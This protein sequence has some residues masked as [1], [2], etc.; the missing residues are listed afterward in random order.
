MP[1]YRP[2]IALL[3]F[4]VA[5]PWFAACQSD[6]AGDPPVDDPADA[7][8][9]S[10]CT[11]PSGAGTEHSGTLGADE[12]W[13]AAGSPHVIRTNLHV[14]TGVTLTL[15]PCAVVRIEG[16]L[17]ILV[18]GAMA[19]EGAAGQPIRIERADSATAW[20]S[21]ETRTGSSLRLAYATVAG[22]GEPNGGR[23]TQFGML[24]IRGDVQ[25]PAEPSFFVDHVVLEDSASIG[26]WLSG[27]AGFAPGS[28]ELTI[29]K[30]AGFPMAVWS[31]AIWT[32]P[33]SGSFTGNAIDEIW[34]PADR[35]A[36]MEDTTL[37]DLG[38]P[39]RVGGLTGGK[40]LGVSGRDGDVALLTIEPGVTLRFEP[41]VVLEIPA[42]STQPDGKPEG[43]LHA[44]GTAGQPIVF[45]SALETPAAG[46]WVGIVF[47]GAP[48]PRNRMEYTTIAYAGAHSG[49]SSFD[50][51]SPANEGFRNAG[52]ILFA[53]G[54]PGGFIRNSTIDSSA[55]DGIVRGWTGEPIDMLA[56]NTFT[57]VA[58]CNQTFPKPK[59]GQ[60][61]DPAPC[62]K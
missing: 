7:A 37:R 9:P 45:T 47:E 24:Q 20:T 11:E 22:G 21:I 12:I 26:V 8:V 42:S 41:E 10:R 33:P 15:E 23:L 14:P 13:T 56:T 5:A 28:K 59:Q 62:P 39:Y 32:L 27:G 3:S 58:R 35:D 50:C 38:V 34:L 54:E 2:P 60:C 30:S 31:R 4:L 44:V 52:A 16:G 19:A 55:G 49:Y 17:G 43:A 57:D 40:S 18:E 61:P 51:P 29:T 48:D 1:S 25:Q 53:G 46:S 6:S 36:I